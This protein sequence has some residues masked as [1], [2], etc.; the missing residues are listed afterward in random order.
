MIES[1]GDEGVSRRG[2][3]GSEPQY[4]LN[5]EIPFARQATDGEI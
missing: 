3:G 5:D 4:D 1:G 2:G